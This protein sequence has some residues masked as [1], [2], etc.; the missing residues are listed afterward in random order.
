MDAGW[1][2]KSTIVL[3]SNC[4]EWGARCK[5]QQEKKNAIKF[6]F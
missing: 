5:A 4:E 1:W 3:H 6:N 2:N